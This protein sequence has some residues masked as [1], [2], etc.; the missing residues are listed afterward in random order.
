[1]RTVAPIAMR[2]PTTIRIGLVAPFLK[3]PSFGSNDPP[4][5]PPPPPAPPG[6]PAGT[7]GIP[8][9]RRPAAISRRGEFRAR[10]AERAWSMT[11]R[12]GGNDT[13]KTG[14]QAQ[15]SLCSF[16][17]D[18]SLSSRRSSPATPT[19]SP[20]TAA[21]TP[22][23]TRSRRRRRWSVVDA[24][25]KDIVVGPAKHFCDFQDAQFCADF[26][27]PGDA[28]RASARRT[29]KAAGSSRS[30]INRP[31]TH[32]RWRSRSSRR[33]MP[34]ARHHRQPKS[35]EVG[36]RPEHADDRRGGRLS[37]E[38]GLRPRSH[39]RVPRRRPPIR[40]SPSGSRCTRT[41]GSSHGAQ[42]AAR[43]RSLRNR[44][45]INGSTPSS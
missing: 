31:G 30:R 40:S 25:G 22:S 12:G 28:A 24:P 42:A 17:C 2:R 9:C 36:H 33:G 5:K 13:S 26:D 38:H 3:F 20:T 18:A 37:R 11:L 16:P 43:W 32:R 10:A 15:N 44:R 19:P 21:R 23:P 6:M 29:S 8:E 7:P 39:Q 45:S 41:N 1:M 14:V 34:R 35:R 27:I 4:P